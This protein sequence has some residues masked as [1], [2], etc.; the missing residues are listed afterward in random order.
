M[1][2]KKQELREIDQIISRRMQEIEDQ[3]ED[4]EGFQQRL[5]AE[6]QLRKEAEHKSSMIQIQLER[7]QRKLSKHDLE[8]QKLHQKLREIHLELELRRASAS[9]DQGESA[10]KIQELVATLRTEHQRTK[11]EMLQLRDTNKNLLH[12]SVHEQNQKELLL[13]QIIDLK[14][15]FKE[16]KAAASKVIES[17]DSGDFSDP[18]PSDSRLLPSPRPSY[19]PLPNRSPHGSG[20]DS[21]DDVDDNIDPNANDLDADKNDDDDDDGERASARFLR[22]YERQ[23]NPKVGAW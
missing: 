10:K 7:L 20:S 4:S 17:E 23:H 12:K 15:Q 11:E 6:E 9:P 13:K 16:L 14:K 3:K 21:D 2:T 8:C 19:P 22:L 18:A 5:Q 1:Q